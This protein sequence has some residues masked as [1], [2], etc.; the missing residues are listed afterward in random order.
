MNNFSIY[1]NMDSLDYAKLTTAAKSKTWPK[2]KRYSV[3]C[4]GIEIK[5]QTYFTKAAEHAPDYGYDAYTAIKSM[6]R[7]ELRR[8]EILHEYDG[9]PQF[10]SPE[11][12]KEEIV[13]L[14]EGQIKNRNAFII[15]VAN[16]INNQETMEAIVHAAAKKKN[17]TLH[18][19]R[20]VKIASTG[21]AYFDDKV[22]AIVARAKT[23]TSMS[24]TFEEVLCRP[25]DNDLWDADFISTYHQGLPISEALAEAL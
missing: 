22:Y 23:D 17:G 25:G 12:N 6:Y 2:G 18:K 21:I 8:E 15:A 16:L 13:R 4:N 10:A 20:V 14:T 11:F 9:T 1:S 24:I 3:N 19:N 7:R 5:I